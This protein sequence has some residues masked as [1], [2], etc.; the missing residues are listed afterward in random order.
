VLCEYTLNGEAKVSTIANPNGLQL[1]K[2]AHSVESNAFVV[3][4]ETGAVLELTNDS[5]SGTFT[6]DS[7]KTIYKSFT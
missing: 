3:A 2:L 7:S 6:V 5:D 4:T 1:S